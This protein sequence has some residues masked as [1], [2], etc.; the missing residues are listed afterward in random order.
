MTV[1]KTNQKMILKEPKT[2]TARNIPKTNTTTT[3]HVYMQ[4]LPSQ[5]YNN[6]MR[7]KECARRKE[8]IQ[9]GGR[10]GEKISVNQLQQKQTI[11]YN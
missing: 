4:K 11:S 10:T 2:T 7:W 1:Q 9:C 3:K 6:L 5:N 8:S